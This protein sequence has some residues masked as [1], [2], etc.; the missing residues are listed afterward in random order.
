MK[1]LRRT[2]R[3]MTA[4]DTAALLDTAEFGVL[5]T[6][7]NDSQPCGVPL[8]YVLKNNA[9]Y[10]HCALSGQKLD[11]IADN[12]RVSFC[13]VGKTRLLPDQFATEYESTVAFGLASTV[14]GTERYDAL[15]WLLEKYCGDFI[16]AGK[17]YIAL[18]DNATKVIKITIDH[19]SG[20]ARR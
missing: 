19:I 20:K 6:C 16:A 4:Q 15:V 5:S 8:N 10:F 9:I 12:P 17:D 13:V 7:G 3:A 1:P 11:N 2:D 18:K 14:E